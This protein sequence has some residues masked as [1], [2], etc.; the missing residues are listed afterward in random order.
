MRCEL[1]EVFFEGLG[2]NGLPLVDGSVCNDCNWGVI[3]ARMLAW[4][5]EE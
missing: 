3:V 4:R 2:H 5:E 1:C